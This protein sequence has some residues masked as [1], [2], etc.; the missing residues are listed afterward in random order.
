V[1]TT[2]V[3][4]VVVVV[5]GGGHGVYGGGGG[6]WFGELQKSVLDLYANRYHRPL[7]DITAIS[8]TRSYAHILKPIDLSKHSCRLVTDDPLIIQ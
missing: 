1:R 8:G 4:V 6:V 2:V 7:S 3:V 5:V